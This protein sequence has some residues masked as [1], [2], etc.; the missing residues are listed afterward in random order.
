MSYSTLADIVR[1]SF[2]RL[3]RKKLLLN[4]LVADLIQDMKAIHGDRFKV[5]A[6]HAVSGRWNRDGLRRIIQN[7]VVNALKYGSKTAPVTL[8]LTEHD[9]VASLIVH[10]EDNPD[11]T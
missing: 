8:T 5:E 11:S 10:N 9:S 4:D 3:I 7:L 2:W 6:E 1:G